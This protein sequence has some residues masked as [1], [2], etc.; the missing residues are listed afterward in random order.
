[1]LLSNIR[2][3]F[4]WQWTQV[5]ATMFAKAGYPTVCVETTG[6]TNPSLD[7]ATMRSIARRLRHIG[8]KDEPE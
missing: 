5:L 6:I 8:H 2:W 1:V 4:L 7:L 3:D